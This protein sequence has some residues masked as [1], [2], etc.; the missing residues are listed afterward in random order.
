[1]ASSCR[2]ARAGTLISLRKSSNSFD[3]RRQKSNHPKVNHDVFEQS[4]G[5][6][7]PQSHAFDLKIT[8][9][10]DHNY[11]EITELEEKVRHYM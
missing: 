5:D 8:T 3:V 2:L 9:P 10:E 7:K 6:A 4:F 1:M 11:P